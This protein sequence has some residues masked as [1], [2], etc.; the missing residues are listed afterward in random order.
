MSTDLEPYRVDGELVTTGDIRQ[1]LRDRKTDSW[2]EVV[3]QVAAF[4]TSIA[5]TL[6]VPKGLRDNPAAVTGAIMYGREVGFP[7]MTSLQVLHNIDG[8]VSMSAEGQRALVLQAGHEIVVEESTSA[9]CTIKGRRK[10]STEWT[11]TTWTHADA[12]AAGLVNK[13]NWKKYPKAMLVARASADLCRLAFPDVIRGLMA[14]E[15]LEDVVAITGGSDAPADPET[16]AKVQRAP[17]KKA[18]AAPKAAV[19]DPDLPE[20]GADPQ[21][22]AESDEGKPDAGE[23]PGQ[24]TDSAPP[25][26][27][28]DTPTPA[29]GESSGSDAASS[30]PSQAS[31]PLPEPELDE[32]GAVPAEIVEDA[33]PRWTPEQ[34]AKMMA[35][36]TGLGVEDRA[37]RLQVTIDLIGRPIESANELTRKEA[38]SVIDSLEQCKTRDDLEAIIQATVAHRESE[39]A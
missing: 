8:K 14:V 39:G 28:E 11:R 36:F 37:E 16:P 32:D 31:E 19:P 3:T 12:R 10:G 20:D 29:S 4:A 25:E 22:G 24:A 23:A 18:A 9:V 17:R 13:D 34:R 6:F 21:T 35:G 33:E 38:S 5:P 30:T 26:L 1:D 27:P 2:T 7:P 15:E